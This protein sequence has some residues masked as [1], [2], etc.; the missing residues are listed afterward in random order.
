MLSLIKIKPKFLYD[1]LSPLYNNENKEGFN[2]ENLQKIMRE[3]S[4]KDKGL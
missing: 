1:M 3:E 2:F 4:D